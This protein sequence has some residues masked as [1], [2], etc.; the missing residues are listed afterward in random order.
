[1]KKISYIA[2]ALSALF[3]TSCIDEE[4]L[5]YDAYSTDTFYKTEADARANLAAVYNQTAM[6]GFWE[7]GNTLVL[8]AISDNAYCPHS[9]Q[10]PYF[11]GL[12]SATA[13]KTGYANLYS[14][15]FTY[16]GIKTAN[17]FLENIDK[18]DMAQDQKDLMKME[19][20]FLRAFNYARKMMFFGGV[21]LV[22]KTL[23]YGEELEFERKSEKEI[24]AFVLS[25]LDQAAKVLPLENERGRITKGA[26]LALKA[27]VELFVGDYE[28]AEKDAKAVMEL[29]KY[30]LYS[31]YNGLF[32]EKN[33]NDP[34]RNK[35][36]ILEVAYK[37]PDAASGVSAFY[38]ADEGGWSLV[39]P[40]QSLV[41]AYE[42][43]NGL[44]IDKDPSYNPDKP[45]ENRDPRL[46]ATVLYPGANWNSRI[47]NSLQKSMSPKI[48]KN[49]KQQVDEKGAPIFVNDFYNDANQSKTGYG[50]RK[51]S[52]SMND[53]SHDPWDNQAINFIVIRYAEVL[54]TYAE[55]LIEQNKDL[56]V[57]AKTIN[58]VRAR[59]GMPAVTESDQDGLRARLRNERRVELAMEG[60]RWIDMKRWKIAEKVM[61]GPVKGV[62]VGKIDLTTM[63]IVFTGDNITV[64]D[65]RKF[66]PKK[67][68]YFPIPQREINISP[69]LT[70]NPNW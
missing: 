40:T 50:M 36:V 21:P 61:N 41:D 51:Y 53:L 7:D 4:R 25:E 59:V 1:M 8:D 45:Y 20:R 69:K 22:T 5:P 65:A 32:L 66:D 28:N 70:Q 31:D 11:I 58:D 52:A 49:G 18:V 56:T 38:T 33:Q 2:V 29:K 9:N 23:K 6:S 16:K 26:A 43:T 19:V 57:A 63:K 37:Y 54:L 46:S 44:S 67:D 42:T 14:D 68:Y 47:F 39:N 17:Y 10:L 24:A 62:R 60:F 13:D 15:F 34:N 64:G 55:A 48:D 27:R 30:D 3:F 12:G 35:E